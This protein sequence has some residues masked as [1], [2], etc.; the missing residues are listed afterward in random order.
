MAAR[1]LFNVTNLAEYLNVPTWLT[2][3]L[4]EALVYLKCNISFD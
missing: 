3:R 2:D 4:L 1:L